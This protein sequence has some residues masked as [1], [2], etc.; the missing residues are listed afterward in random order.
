MKNLI[1]P[2]FAILALSSCTHYYYM[3]SA[4]NTPLF[5]E[6][7][8]FR[9]T[10]SIGKGDRTET[11]HAQAAYAI[12]NRLAIA[13]SHMNARGGDL[14]NNNG[15]KGQY[16]DFSAGY[17]NPFH[18]NLVFEVFGGFGKSK[19][20]HVY[21]SS[22]NA[23]LTFTKLFV[24]PSIGFTNKYFDYAFTPTFS[25]VRY[26]HIS[27]NISA[28]DP[29]NE[30]LQNIAQRKNSILFEPTF[31]I[32]GG[33]QF[34]KIQTQVGSSRNL[35]NRNLAFEEIQLNVGFSFAFAQ[36]ML[37]KSSRDQDANELLND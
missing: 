4:P 30:A 17:F 7:N 9:A 29:E 2:V 24:Q 34:F 5:R 10:A 20:R 1:F 8:E 19:Q 13:G 3:P 22:E 11:V 16:T 25:Q 12:T 21:S 6:K 26:H 18:K 27:H 33:W 28:N 31:T 36:R 14:V 32:R 23:N 35:T 15:A 37:K